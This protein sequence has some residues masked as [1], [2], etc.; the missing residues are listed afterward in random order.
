MPSLD[1]IFNELLTLCHQLGASEHKLAILS[2]GNTSTVVDDETFLIK[3]SGCRLATMQAKHLVRVRFRD[4]L[5]IIDLRLSDDETTEALQRAKVE[6]TALKPSVEST[7]HGWLLKQEGIRF[8]AH[9]HPTGVCKILCSDNASDFANR[10]IFPDEIVCCGPKSLLIDYVDPGTELA[11]AIQNG[12]NS[13]VEENGFM[14]KVILIRNHGLITVGGS[15]SLALSATLMAAKAAEIFAGAKALGNIVFMD[16]KEIKR[17]H[18]RT[19]E[20]YRQKLL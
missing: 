13:F 2:E 3:A 14:P 17:I 11:R 19:D 15:A 10:R 8:V 9:T 4:I 5:S 12:W 7:F 20:H 16:E 1:T 18:N 6:K